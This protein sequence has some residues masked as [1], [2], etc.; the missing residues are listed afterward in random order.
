MHKTK[1]SKILKAKLLPKQEW[2]SRSRG[3]DNMM[4]LY[5]HWFL[6]NNFNAD[7]SQ[8]FIHKSH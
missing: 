8:D 1:M 4:F 3:N 6:K 5:I 7:I 2:G